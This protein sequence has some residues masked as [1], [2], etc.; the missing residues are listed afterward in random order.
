MS[1]EYGSDRSPVVKIARQRHGRST[2]ATGHR[3]SKSHGRDMAEARQRPVTGCQNRTA[4]TWQ[5]HG[6]D[7]SPVVKIARQRHGRSTAAT[8]HRLSKSHGRHGMSTAATGHRLSKSHGRNMAG[9]RQRPA[10]GC[11]NRTAETWHEYGSDRSPVVKIARQR[12]GRSTAATGHRLSKSHGRDMAGARQR[13]VTGCQ[14]RTA[15]TW[16]EHGSDRSPVVKI[17]RQKHG[18]NTAATGHRLSKSHGRDMAGYV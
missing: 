14:N 2:A 7:R 9:A 4:E 16:Q 1:P 12:H 5:E 15:E 13:P 3:L 18:R 11:Q 6:S 8:G 17:A 10:T